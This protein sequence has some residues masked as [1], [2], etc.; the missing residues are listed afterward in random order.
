MP[1]LRLAPMKRLVSSFLRYWC[2]PPLKCD[3]GER[4]GAAFVRNLQAQGVRVIEHCVYEIE[5]SPRLARPGTMQR[6]VPLVE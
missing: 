2:S 5:G 3:G 1:G 4:P 6:I